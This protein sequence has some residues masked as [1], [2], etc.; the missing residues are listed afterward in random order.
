[1]S[2]GIWI[3]AI[4]FFRI[5]ALGDLETALYFSLVTFTTLG[6]GDIILDKPFRL[7]SGL[8]AADGLILFGLTT[9]FLIEFVR[10][11]HVAQSEATDEG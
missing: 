6:F 5:G 7:L 11:L 9:A 4:F 3:W 1:M 8:L 10:S 2:V